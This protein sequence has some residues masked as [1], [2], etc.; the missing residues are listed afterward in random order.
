M[1]GNYPISDRNTENDE[2]FRLSNTL[3]DECKTT[4]YEKIMEIKDNK[5]KTDYAVTTIN[6]LENDVL[7]LRNQYKI[8]GYCKSNVTNIINIFLDVNKLIKNTHNKCLIVEENFKYIINNMR[9]VNNH[10]NFKETLRLKLIEFY[11][12]PIFKERAKHFYRIIF[13]DDIETKN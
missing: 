2:F 4:I 3:I 12:E 9:F 11:K 1:E 7:Q 6:K 13:D 8:D 5:E 10:N